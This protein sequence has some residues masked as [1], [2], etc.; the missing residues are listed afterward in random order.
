ML[1]IYTYIVI[2]ILSLACIFNVFKRIVEEGDNIRVYS[3][4]LGAF[5]GAILLFVLSIIRIIQIL[6]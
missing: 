1:N 2:A 5:L 6:F 3:L 4:K